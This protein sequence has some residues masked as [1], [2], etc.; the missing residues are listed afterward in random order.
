MRSKPCL[1][2]SLRPPEHIRWRFV[3]VGLVTFQQIHHQRRHQRPRKQ[4]R[5]QHGEYHRFRQGD[6][7]IASHTGKKEHGHEHNADGQGR[8]QGRYRDL[9]RAIENRLLQLLLHPQVALNIFDFDGGV[10]DQDADCQRQT[11]PAS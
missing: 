10:I 11:L 5:R 1:E 8:N 4:V 3:R 7:Q 2:S 9:L 6:E